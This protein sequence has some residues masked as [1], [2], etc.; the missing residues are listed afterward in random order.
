MNSKQVA[1]IITWARSLLLV[2]YGWFALERGAKSLPIVVFLT[3][4]N[5]T[6]DSIDGPLARRSRVQYKTW[7][8]DRDL[9]VDMAITVGLLIYLTA[10][11]FLAWQIA[12]A[13][14]IAFMGILWITDFHS[15]MGKLFQG[16]I[17]L[18]F[19]IATL[20]ELPQAVW[21]IFAW[22]VIA[23]IVTW[24]KLPRVI[25]PTFINGFR[26]VWSKHGPSG[27]SLA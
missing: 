26:E 19:I 24:P 25:I 3:I 14:V 13:Y 10:S 7:I 5:W 15:E 8:G 9:E 12:A 27:G 23:G 6:L 11:G 20:R 22:M 21:W 2:V 1:D 18:V 16:P 4:A 17:Y